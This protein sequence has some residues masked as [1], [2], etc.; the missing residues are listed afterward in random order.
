MPQISKRPLSRIIYERIFKIFIE[1]IVDIKDKKESEDFL[2]DF[3]TPTERIMLAKR[4]T[5]AILLSKNY[6]YDTI[7]KVLHV[8]NTTISSVNNYIKFSG[9]GYRKVIDKFLKKEAIKDLL[10]S[11]VEDVASL[12]SI[13]GKGS[14]VW[15][16][17]K[18]IVQE[19]KR[20][21]PF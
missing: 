16:T 1:V 8:S 4:L 2:K 9:E 13:G 3:L 21:K 17:V 18:K 19:N 6:D 14:Y 7:H 10:S 5:I 20:K 11:I 15:K 12:G